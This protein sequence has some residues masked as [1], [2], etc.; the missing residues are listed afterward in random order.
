MKTFLKI[1]MSFFSIALYAQTETIKITDL[2]LPNAP[3]FTIL[4]YAPTIISNPKTTQELT[5][6]LINS[7][8]SSNGIPTDY[9]LE[10]TPFW[11]FSGE[12][13]SLSSYLKGEEKETIVKPYKNLSVSLAS[14]KKDSLQ[15]LS[16]GIR[17]NIITINSKK[18]TQIVQ[19]IN[20]DLVNIN[21]KIDAV[22][23]PAGD[24]EDP[25]AG[26]IESGSEEDQ[27]RDKEKMD[28]LSKDTEYVKLI[29]KIDD[30][31]NEIKRLKAKPVLSIDVAGAYNHFFDDA[32]FKSGKFGRL[33]A[34]ATINENLTF[35]NNAKNYICLYQYARY[36]VDEMD[37]DADA[38][39]YIKDKSLDLGA[40]VELQIN[41]LTLGYEYVLRTSEKDNYRSV[42]NIKYKINDN[43][44][45]NGGFGK[46]FEATDDL[47]S[48]L[49][50]SWG[51]SQNNKLKVK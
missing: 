24:F 1:V 34:W 30:K 31:L 45:L 51:L 42:G 44:V 19:S 23:K 6:S 35:S 48:F 29:K 3:A 7:V 2:E 9:A 12:N 49:G 22:L 11:T 17:T 5:L 36:L 16:F 8:S 14:V 21:K 33:G 39:T 50:V 26:N 13:K 47:I 27:Q 37:Y 41:D 28:Q 32:E 10:F 46:N 4:D 43:V 38:M 25:T 20:N 18:V 15:N 40:K